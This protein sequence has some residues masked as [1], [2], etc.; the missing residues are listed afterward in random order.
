MINYHYVSSQYA[1]H[2]KFG[3]QVQAEVL[4]Q[5]KTCFIRIEAE[6]FLLSDQDANDLLI[7]G[8]GAASSVYEKKSVV[9]LVRQVLR[10]QG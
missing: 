7:S 1:S 9:L 8:T 4:N 3:F 5:K 10:F 6:I 2:S